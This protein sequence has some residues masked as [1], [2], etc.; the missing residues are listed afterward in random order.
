VR[1]LI[2]SGALPKLP[3]HASNLACVQIPAASCRVTSN[4]KIGAA[5]KS[6]APVAPPRRAQ[7][8]R[9]RALRLFAPPDHAAI[10]GQAVIPAA[11]NL[12][13]TESD[14]A[15]SHQPRQAAI[16]PEG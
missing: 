15:Y 9:L 16:C 1:S 5:I 14:A 12:H 3:I 7:F 10:R 4:I 13:K 11:E 2:R 8:P 6:H